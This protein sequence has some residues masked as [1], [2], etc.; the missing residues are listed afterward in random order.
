MDPREL[1]IFEKIRD[2]LPKADELLKGADSG[3]LKKWSVEK[4][5]SFVAEKTLGSSHIINPDELNPIKAGWE[6]RIK[7]IKHFLELR[8]YAKLD[9][10]AYKWPRLSAVLRTDRRTFFDFEKRITSSRTRDQ[11]KMTRPQ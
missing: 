10:L 8:R 2:G 9:A 4:R 1:L 11:P 5:S 6:L 3:P 7:A